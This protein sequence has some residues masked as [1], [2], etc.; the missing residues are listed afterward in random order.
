MMD[1]NDV[2]LSLLPHLIAQA[3][4]TAAIEPAAHRRDVINQAFAWADTF[5]EVRVE[6]S[7]RGMAH[8]LANPVV[9]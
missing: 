8:M 2:A 3:G 5:I 7:S 4:S 1:R 6:H 9:E